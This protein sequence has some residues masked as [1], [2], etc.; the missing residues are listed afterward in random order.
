MNRK[1][2]NHRGKIVAILILCFAVSAVYSSTLFAQDL[3]SGSVL[4]INRAGVEELSSLPGIG[5]A[6]AKAIVDYRTNNGSFAS[7]EDL[8]SVK[9]IGAKVLEKIKDLITAEVR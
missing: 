2:Q 5:K 4:N 7:L 9:G 3:K 1:V 6:K 8:L